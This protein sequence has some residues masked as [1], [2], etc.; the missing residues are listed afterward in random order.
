MAKR[1]AG[2]T[3]DRV[4]RSI[5]MLAC[6]VGG[7]LSAVRIVTAFLA[8]GALAAGCETD[9][10][11]LGATGGRIEYQSVMCRVPECAGRNGPDWARLESAPAKGDIY[12]EHASVVRQGSETGRN[13]V[14]YARKPGEVLLCRSVENSD[15]GGY[16]AFWRFREKDGAVIVAESYAWQY[17]MVNVSGC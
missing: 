4:D 9:A 16:N 13:D 6:D 17:V 1:K 12:L 8:L 3:I 15:R 11:Y 10:D 7:K 2:L 5:R 14:W